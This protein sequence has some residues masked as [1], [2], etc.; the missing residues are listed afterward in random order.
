MDGVQIKNLYPL[1]PMQEG[2]LFHSLL[3][4]DHPAYHQQMTLTLKGTINLD[5]IEQS[6]NALIARYDV[7]RTVFLVENVE[8]PLQVVLQERTLTLIQEDIAALPEEEQRAFIRRYEEEDRR[9]GFDL[10]SDLLMRVSVLVT[11]A[12][13]CAMVWSFHHII[14]DGWCLGIILDDF[15]QAYE[16]LAGGLP[17]LEK[18]VYPYSDYMEWL[19]QQ[20]KDG[21]RAYWQECLAGYEQQAVVPGMRQDQKDRAYRGSEYEFRFPEALTQKLEQ[22]AKAQG[23]TLSTVLQALWGVLLHKYNYSDDVVYGTVVSGRPSSLTGVEQMVGLFINTIPVRVQSTHG[24]TFTELLQAVQQQSLRSN[25]NAFFPLAEIQADSVLRSGLI[26]HLVV[27]ENYP[28][29]EALDSRYPGLGFAIEDVRVFEQTSYDFNLMVVPGAQLKLAFNYNEAVYDSSFVAAIG[30]HLLKLAEAAAGDPAVPLHTIEIITEA[31]AEQLASFNDTAR[32]YPLHKPYMEL[33]AE[34]V[35][36]HR[37]RTALV[38]E[39]ALLTYGELDCRVDRL[40]ARLRGRGVSRESIVGIMVEPSLEMIVG[41]LAVL[42][43]GGAFLPI[44]PGYPQERVQYFLTDSG[45]EILLTQ[46]RFIGTISFAGECLNLEDEQLYNVDVPFPEG[47]LP[48]IGRPD[49]LAYVIYTSGSTGQPKGVMIEH[50]ALVNLCFWHNSEYGVTPEDRTAKYA[51]FSFD[52]SVWEIFPYLI[53]GASIHMLHKDIRLDIGRLNRYFETNSIT[54]TY[55]PT[56][57][58]EQ[59]MKVQNRSLR[60]LLTAGDKLKQYVPQTYKLVN[61]YGPTENAV[62]TTFYYVDRQQDNIP[63]GIPVHNHRVYVLDKGGKQVPAGVPGELCVSG[64]GLARGYWNKPDLT[65]EKFTVNPYE[66]GER[67]YRTGD[68]AVWM[69]DGNIQ[70]LGRIDQQVKIRGHRIEIGEIETQLMQLAAVRDC[71]VVPLKDDNDQAYLC[72]YFVPQQEDMADTKQLRKQL[73]GLLPDYMVPAVFM[74]LER[75]PVNVNGKI[76]RKALPKPAVPMVSGYEAPSGELENHLA[77][78]WGRVLGLPRVGRQDHF[79]EMGGHS[80]KAVMLVTEMQQSIDV[81]VQIR[82]IFACPT[83]RELAELLEERRRGHVAPAGGPEG[84]PAA[85]VRPYYPLSSA[86]RRLYVLSQMEG[87]GTSYHLPGALLLEG[88]LSREKLEQT[89]ERMLDRHEALRTRFIMADGEPV[90]QIM[91]PSPFRLPV[92]ELHPPAE[93]GEGEGLARYI[94]SYME[95]QFVRP[96]ELDHAPLMRMELLKLGA[97]RHVLLYDMHHLITDGTSTALFVRDFIELYNEET[98]APLELHYKDYAVWQHERLAAGESEEDGK[99]WLNTFADGIPVLQLPADYTRPAVRRFAGNRTVFTVDP[100]AAAR[101]EQLA[102]DTGSTLYMVLLAAYHLLLAGHSGQRDIVIGTPVSGRTHADMH[103]MLGMFVNTLPLRTVSRPDQTVRELLLGIRELVLQSLEHQ[104]Y[105]FEELVHR[106]APERDTGRNPLFDTMFALQNMDEEEMKLSGLHVTPLAVQADMAKYDLT[107]IG[108]QHGGGL[109]FEL[110]YSTDLFH[111]ATIERWA[112]HY[113]ELLHL[114][115]READTALADVSCLPEQEKELLLH[116]FNRTEL[117]VEDKLLHELFEEQAARTPDHPALADSS[118]R[119]TFGELNDRAN[120]L[121][122][123][124]RSEGAAPGQIVGVSTDR[125]VDVVTAMLA[126]LKAGAAYLPLDPSYP[127]ERLRYFAEDSGVRL[128]VTNHDAAA[129]LLPA[130]GGRVIDMRDQALLEQYEGANL[131]RTA[132]SGDLAYVIY[133]S[134]STG[135]PKGVMIEHRSIAATLQWRQ[136]VYRFDGRDTALAI[137]PYAFDGFIIGCLSPLFGGA[138]VVMLDEREARDP[139]G[140]RDKVV[141][142]QATHLMCIPSLYAGI[143]GCSE[144]GQ[145]KTLRIAALGGERLTA[146]VVQAHWHHCPETVLVNEYGPTENSVTSTHLVLAG[147][148]S[149][150]TI[151]GPNGNMQAFI[152]DERQRLLPIGVPGELCVSGAGLARGY[153][154]RPELTAEKFVDHPYR[155]GERL[156]RT[157]DL[158]RFRPDGRIEYLGRIDHQVKIRGY[159]IELGEIEEALLAC[160]GVREAVVID[161]TGED[162]AAYLCAYVVAQQEWNGPLQTGELQA[163]LSGKLPHY[164]IP[165]RFMQLDSIPL[166]PSGKADRQAL[167]EPAAETGS[168]RRFAAP[169]G[170]AEQLLAGIWQEVLGISRIGR[171]DSFFQLG[172]DS[173]KAIQVSSRLYKAGYAMEMK[174]LFQEPVLKRFAATLSKALKRAEQ[175]PVTGE[176]PLTPIQRWFFGRRFTDAHHFNQSVV[177][178]RR[179]RFEPAK[180][181]AVLDKLTQHHDALRAVFHSSGAGQEP[182]QIIRGLDGETFDFQ[183]TDMRAEPNPAYQM[184]QLIERTQQSF[185]LHDGPLVK[186]VLMQAPEGDHLLL[187]VHHLVVDGVSWRIMLEDFNLLYRQAL[188]GTPLTLQEKTFSYKDWALALQEYA[189]TSRLQREAAYWEDITAAAVEQGPGA[190][191]ADRHADKNTYQTSRSLTASL[192]EADTSR[193]LRQAPQAYGTEVNELLLTA[194]GLAVRDWSGLGQALVTLEG[195]GREKIRDDLNISRTVG[196]FTSTFPVRLDLAGSRTL[197]DCIQSMKESMRRIPKRGIGYGILKELGRRSA[198]Q[199]EADTGSGIQPAISFNYLGQFDQDIASELF[200]LS[201]LSMGELISPYMER[202]AEL[203]FNGM[204]VEGRLTFSLTYN[205]LQYEDGTAGRL[206]GLFRHHL[207]EIINHCAQLTETVRTPSDYGCHNL[208]LQEWAGIQSLAAERRAGIADLYPLTPMQEGMLFHALKDADSSAYVEQMSLQLEGELDEAALRSSLAVLFDCHPVLR[209][210]FVYEGLNRPYQVVLDRMEPVIRLADWSGRAAGEQDE[211]LSRF[212]QEDL[213]RGFDLTRDPL[214]RLTVMKLGGEQWRLVWTHHHI[215]M[216]GWCLGLLFEDLFT[217]YEAVL[218]GRTPEPAA[219]APYR[220]YI[221]W[222]QER[223]REEAAAYWRA[224]LAGYEEPATLPKSAAGRREGYEQGGVSFTLDRGLTSELNRLASLHE[225]T[226]NTVV[227]AVWAV[228]LQRYNDTDEVVFGSVVSGRPPEVAGIEEMIGLFI[229]TIPVR[230]RFTGQSFG[231]LLQDAKQS[232]LEA[233]Q[234]DYLSLADIQAVSPLKQH[235]FDHILVFENTPAHQDGDSRNDRSRLGFTVADTEVYEQTSYDFDITVGP[236]EELFFK[237][238]YN[239]RVYD[240]AIIRQLAGHFRQIAEQAAARPEH[241]AEDLEL[242]TEADKHLLTAGFNARKAPVD[243]Q[244]TVPLLFEQQA[245]AVPD[246]TAVVFGEEKHSYEAVNRHANQLAHELSSRGAG[247]ETLV[248]VLMERSPRMIETILGIWKAGGAYIP[249]DPDYPV[250]RKLAILQESG[251]RYMVSASDYLSDL[252]EEALSEIDCILLDQEEEAIVSRSSDN[253]VPLAAGDSLAYVI[254]TSGSTGKP[255]GAMIEHAGMLNHIAAEIEELSLGSHSVI[256]Q[257]ANH[258]FDISVWQMFAALTIGGTTAIAANDVILEPQRFLER[259]AADEV[260]VLEVVPSY[261]AL[262]MDEIRVRQGHGLALQYLMITGET[263]K[264][265][266]V[267]QWF[268]LCPDIRMVNAYGPAEAAD[269]ISQYVME[270][271][272][273][274]DPVPIGGPVRNMNLYIVDR[275]LRLLPVGAV[276]E[277]CVSG[278][279]VGRGYLNDEERTKAVFMEDPYAAEK[280]LR[281]YRTGDL[282]RWLP[283]GTV[284]FYG[285]RDN[286]VKIRGYRVELGEIE[287]KLVEHAQ[288]REAVVLDAA[289]SQGGR[290]LCAYIVSTG[291]EISA[292]E[293]RKHAAELL[294]D[295]MVPSVF[296]MLD[297]MPLSPNGKIDRRALPQPDRL[298]ADGWNQA[299]AEAGTRTEM[300]QGLAQIWS[301]ILGVG[302]GQI[303][304]AHSFFELGGHSL[305][306]MA[307]VAQVRGQ[308]GAELTIRDIFAS[309]VLMEQAA[310]LEGRQSNRTG[311]IKPAQK[312]GSYPVS[313]AQKRMFI[314]SQMPGAELS[315]NIP[316]FTLMEGRLDEER[317]RQALEELVHRHEALRTSFTLAGGE[318]VQRIHDDARLELE[319]YRLGGD[320]EEPA[321]DEAVQSIIDAF[322]R[323][324]DL[325]KAPLMRAG[326]IRLSEEQ[327]LLMLDVHHI[328]SDGV[329]SGLLAAEFA[330]FYRGEALPLP[331]VHYKDFAVWQQEQ[332]QD[333]LFSRQERYWLEQLAGELPVLQ[334]PTDYVRPSYKSY[335]GDRMEFGTDERLASA[336]QA[337]LAETGTTLYMYLLAAFHVLLSKYSG[338]QDIIVGSPVAGRHYAGLEQVCGMFVNTLPLRIRSSGEWTFGELLEQAKEMALGAYENQDYPMDELVPML[339]MA[340]DPGRSPLFDAVL[341]IQNLDEP[342]VDLGSVKLRPYPVENKTAKFDVTLMAVEEDGRLSFSMEYCTALFRQETIRQMT[343]DYCRILQTV[344]VDPMIRLDD[345]R[346]SETPAVE[347]R[348]ID[349]DIVFEL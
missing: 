20:D 215:L 102:A 4:Q 249:V 341:V 11:G 121:A 8:Q 288:V 211:L 99:Y 275:Q 19:L 129:G 130:D 13:S 201:R 101:L 286:Q 72:A 196:W 15:F 331:A 295:Y 287:A 166:A 210:M 136:T 197:A 335:A 126:I 50:S 153:L 239:T 173:I 41:V 189:D 186:A 120:R 194:L 227:Q 46:T 254:Y 55:L 150:I 53:C 37:E 290:Y 241:P 58:A 200:E 10:T 29:D 71:V 291:G 117:L 179:D 142:E 297:E 269:D 245:A 25:D 334:L 252:P 54:I 160:P 139:A 280:G 251:V 1:T 323:P 222:L 263:V 64:S 137:Y 259:I 144:P 107:L 68:L 345:I 327:T 98:L 305:K 33:F 70:Y 235:L 315:Y 343:D 87:V 43:A 176:V 325:G 306:A 181:Y 67:M 143:L 65:D 281:M 344:A 45:A 301:Q 243:M 146:A 316:Q 80:L 285:R 74:E 332:M 168:G 128:I 172:G 333:E 158:A 214:V 209:T 195:H 138:A 262:L 206:I 17:V 279:G 26:Q 163:S 330:A 157:G 207:E 233:M 131:P 312:R 338:Q 14:M 86:Q 273:E 180:L 82:D 6:M 347:D 125:S 260:T 115:A 3:D 255:K 276:G 349:G 274:L 203:E 42:K 57:F 202:Q 148:E 271:A 77:G 264:P 56:Q 2:M 151:G 261:L 246:R 5:Y 199:A 313:S 63:I 90:Q 300:E 339:Q 216:D 212:K 182:V 177:L 84:I 81:P 47:R 238:S 270:R 145:L 9:Q 170:E 188:E 161:R 12:D 226:L 51:G 134:G 244:E 256:A 38:F 124:L 248:A 174:E 309:P 123:L 208:S 89:V 66:P 165:T 268:E 105:P 116:A 292:A 229:N 299:S 140:I 267:K 198:E 133:T 60:V 257:N 232:A 28:I 175:G 296:L 49:D 171:E 24:Q 304:R 44:D 289:D 132:Q 97:D 204:V 322:V 93:H 109:S 265:A 154:N 152:L 218:E 119:L 85:G 27:F 307:L 250:S 110:E 258:C 135:L 162:G 234:H 329:T 240:E 48:L 317:L 336:I 298:Q 76:D 35:E 184:E 340:A 321:V 272:P 167:P 183:V 303:S 149:D 185:D 193:L 75:I 147:G 95:T 237:F 278:I 156:Y 310:L 253:L 100:A 21:A 283:D 320:V 220:A 230:F 293:L 36:L 155:K 324:F 221:G 217:C 88:S 94:Q 141:S 187:T 83:V 228:V 213:A 111:P 39:D 52:C 319:V 61:N 73:E 348:A 178:L 219:R 32:E 277:I 62:I 108:S 302:A 106:L 112:A 236:G 79:F 91:P 113:Q 346:L 16:A 103:R 326:F 31:E 190:F 314:A 205:T 337:R 92:H 59:F 191:P 104:D 311:I 7:L 282:G 225:V 192:S 159:R 164:M 342:E 22:L 231:K 169:Q 23:V 223:E 318:P 18:A 40:A 266:M 284:A 78:L 308:L 118:R 294:P 247:H 30:G 242:L 122:R 34:A 127:A 328:V 224:Y 114:I 96:F 69:P